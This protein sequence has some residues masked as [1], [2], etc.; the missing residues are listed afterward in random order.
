MH[1]HAGRVLV[2]IV[3]LGAFVGC[4]RSGGSGAP[5]RTDGPPLVRTDSE[6]LRFRPLEPP[7]DRVHCLV[8]VTVDC[9]LANSYAP[10]LEAIHREYADRGVGMW[11]VHVDP[12]VD[13]VAARRHAAEYGHT[14]PLVLDP[15]HEL[16]AAV[17]A[18]VTPEAAVLTHDGGIVFSVVRCVVLSTSDLTYT[19]NR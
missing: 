8:F 2:V 14:T 3:L 6:G 18:T 7:V 10:E 5:R 19:V 17:G 1:R 16:V 12:D 13:L 9:P 15:E 11:L 4:E